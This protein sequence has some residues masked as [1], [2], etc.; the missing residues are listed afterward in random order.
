MVLVEDVKG[1][2]D[3]K[4][5]QGRRD[6]EQSVGQYASPSL[7]FGRCC[8]VALHHSLVCAIGGDIGEEGSYKYSPECGLTKVEAK[9]TE[10]KFMVSYS[11]AEDVCHA[12]GNLTHNSHN[13][14]QRTAKEDDNLQGISPDDCLNTTRHSVEEAEDAHEGDADEDIDACDYIDGDGRQKEDD[15]HAAYLK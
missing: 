2:A 14:Q 4:E 3:K 15:T 1:C 7:R 13:C 12:I 9:V 6:A 8:H 11:L 5:E 10:V